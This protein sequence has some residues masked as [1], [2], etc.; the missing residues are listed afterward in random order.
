M[1][2]IVTFTLGPAMTNAY[3]RL[4]LFPGI[5][6]IV[7]E[8]IGPED[9]VALVATSGSHGMY[10]EF[11]NDPWALRLAISRVTPQFVDS[12]WAGPPQLTQYQAE[13]IERGDPRG[14][15]IALQFKARDAS[16]SAKEGRRL[17]QLLR[18]HGRRWLGPLDA[19]IDAAGLEFDR[20]FPSACRA[21]W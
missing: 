8:Q 5:L 7:D 11:T 17:R 18:E 16:L 10:Q 20:G 12:G 3:P 4:V 13:L 6:C 14:E 1:L 2:E 9:R 21:V 15:L 19:V